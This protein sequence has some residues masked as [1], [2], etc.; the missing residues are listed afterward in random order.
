MSRPEADCV[1]GNRSLATF[2]ALVI[3]SGAGGSAVAHVLTAAGWKVLVLEAGNNYFPGLD[4][5]GKLPW[6]DFGSDELRMEVRG[7][8]VQDPRLEPRTFRQTE[9]ETAGA[10]PDVNALTRNVGGAAVISTVSYPRFNVVDFRMASALREARRE[11]PGT[12]FVDWPFTYADLEPFYCETD[13]LCGIAGVA[14]GDGSDPFA[15]WRSRPFP[16][17]PPEEMYAGR[18]LANGAR[19]LGYTPFKYPSAVVT[20]VNV[21]PDDDRAPCVSCGACAHFG[22]PR[23]AKGTPPVTTLRRAL[24]TGNCQLRY[25]CHVARLLVNANQTR[26]TGVEYFDP[27]G[28]IQSATADH[29]VLAASPI[30][31]VRLCL[32][33][34]PDGRGLGNS[35]GHLGRHLMFHFQPTVAGFFRQRLHG[36]RGRSIT[37]GM[38]DFRGVNPADGAVGGGEFLLDDRPLGGVI[39]FAVSSEPILSFTEGLQALPLARIAGVS[40]KDLLVESPFMAHI[41]VLAMMGEDAPQP[42]NRVDLDPTLRDVYDLAVPRITYRNHA[43]ELEMAAFYKPR[44]LDI[45]AAAG[46]EFGLAQPFD[47]SVPPTSRHVM[48]GLRMGDDP[49]TSVCDGFGKFHDL[50][51]LYCGD[52]AVFPTGSGYNPTPTII[53][54]A[55]RTAGNLAHPGRPE[56]ALRYATAG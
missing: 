15:S 48:G 17:P 28:Q 7:H 42:T 10:H 45:L 13:V 32:L 29:Y 22:C 2:D 36:E 37:T 31:S 46:A 44:M 1:L 47:P 33:S 3:G 5:P 21:L 50:E 52:G 40:F 41:G 9:S 16:L 55:L 39:E 27:D 12:S 14:E 18:V 56:R 6:S 49:A 38:S 43:F 26:V 54:V 53:A 23:N 4:Q 30:E 19:R 51:N 34:D 25:N 20:R 24:L 11:F 35:S 8:I